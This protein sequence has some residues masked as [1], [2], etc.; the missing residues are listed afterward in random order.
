MEWVTKKP[1]ESGWYWVYAR[2]HWA[3]DDSDERILA[4]LSIIVTGSGTI[5]IDY[6]SGGY[7]CD[8]DID[9]D[10]VLFFMGPLKEPKPP[11]EQS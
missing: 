2:N 10:D 9:L 8:P 7:E 3:S 1:K 11:K 6:L 5:Y 4:C